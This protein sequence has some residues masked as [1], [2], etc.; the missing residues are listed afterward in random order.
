MGYRSEVILALTDKNL[1]KMIQ[2]ID[3]KILVELLNHAD[4]HE[5]DGWTLI[6]WS[7]VKWYEDY[8]DVAAVNNFISEIEDSE[9]EEVREGFSYH[10]MGEEQDD[11]TAKGTWDT[12][13]EIRLNRSLDF[14]A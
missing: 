13:F 2:G 14:F 11:Y 7:D 1:K 6:H 10:I 4:R 9:D 5:K 8:K 12:P 3:D